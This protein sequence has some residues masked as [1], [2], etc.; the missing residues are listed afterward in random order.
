KQR[1]EGV[2]RIVVRRPDGRTAGRPAGQS[3][4]QRNHARRTTHD[5]RPFH[6]NTIQSTPSITTSRTER[7]TSNFLSS[8][9]S[10][11]FRASPGS[12]T[13]G[14]PYVRPSVFS[15]GGGG[16]IE[17]TMKSTKVQITNSNTA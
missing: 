14:L 2:R 5:A 12:P 3:K 8:F 15:R 1:T 16:V 17:L 4:C 6:A 10:P 7:P 11:T 13:S 9:V